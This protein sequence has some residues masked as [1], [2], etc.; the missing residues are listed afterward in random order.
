MILSLLIAG[1]LFSCNQPSSETV[2]AVAPVD[3]LI[4]NWGIGWNNH[5]SAG[6]RNLFT[7]DAL[8]TDDQL[9]A[10][11]IE[12]ISKKMIGPNIHIASNFTSSKLQEWSSGNRAGYTGTYEIDITINDRKSVV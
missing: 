10:I 9:I 3:S 7:D 4:A 5:D 12:E 8:L 11:G 6:V 2:T 1:L